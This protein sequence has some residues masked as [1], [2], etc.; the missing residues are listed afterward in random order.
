MK[1]GK[2]KSIISVLLEKILNVKIRVIILEVT[3]LCSKIEYFIMSFRVKDNIKKYFM[4]NFIAPIINS[5]MML[6]LC[7][8]YLFD[9]FRVFIRSII[10]E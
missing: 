7:Y 4:I 8:E 10:L 6:D 9:L 5:F 1:M 3:N 2:Q